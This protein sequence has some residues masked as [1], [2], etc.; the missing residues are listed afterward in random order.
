MQVPFE[1]LFQGEEHQAFKWHGGHGAVLLIHGFP[2]TPAEMHP[3]AMLLHEHGWT[4]EAPLLPGFGPD[5]AT[6]E[7]RNCDDWLNTI[8]R[9]LEA[10]QRSHDQVI[11]AG[12][13]M[14]AALGIQAAAHL[15]PDGLVLFAPFWQIDH[16][17]WHV[18]PVLRHV[19]PTF[20][21]FRLM[22]PNFDD[23]N[24]REGVHNFMPQADLDNPETQQ[25]IR[26]FGIP[27]NVINQIRV[28]GKRGYEAA[29]QIRIPS[30]VIQGLQD[31]LVQPRQTRALLQRFSG[32]VHYAELPGAHDILNSSAPA[33][34]L[35]WQAVRDFTNQI[36]NKRS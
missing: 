19:F 22:R 18:M 7:H 17:L 10:L 13:S 12:L 25:A 16:V 33:W 30:L 23:P 27:M 29:A 26:E 9:S 36:K 5:M 4:V 2:G 6:L 15:K 14:G 28:S 31:D 24:F 1:Q 20:K 34:P 35:V 3:L 8:E 11:V 32:Q 21:P